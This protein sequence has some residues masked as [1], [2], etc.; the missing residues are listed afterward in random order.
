[1]DSKAMRKLNVQDSIYAII[2]VEEIATATASVFMD[3]RMLF[4]LP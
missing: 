4:A 1:M 2:E 3:T